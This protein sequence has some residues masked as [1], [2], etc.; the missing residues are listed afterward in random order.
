MAE[1]KFKRLMELG[2]DRVTEIH[3]RLTTGT[4][5][6]QLAT[7]MQQEW[8][9]L[10]DIKIG[11][12]KKMLERFRDSV[13]TK[14]IVKGLIQANGNAETL[15]KRLNALDELEELTKIQKSRFEKMLLRENTG[16]LLLKQVSEERY[17]LMQLLVELGRLQLETGALQRAPKKL[18]GRIVGM[19]GREHA[20]EWTAEQE[21]LYRQI[22]GVDYHE[23]DASPGPGK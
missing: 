17:G 16:P 15:R 5:P 20:F 6:M 3:E 22:E 23:I 18:T 2:E 12:V 14:S 8:G 4:L 13:V 19:D 10:T 1:G 7:E 11:S 9:V 21:Q